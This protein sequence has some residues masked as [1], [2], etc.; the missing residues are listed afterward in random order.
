[1]EPIS[2]SK[3]IKLEASTLTSS[4]M[5]FLKAGLSCRRAEIMPDLREVLVL[6][7]L[8]VFQGHV[9]HEVWVALPSTFPGLPVAPWDVA[10][11]LL[12]TG[13]VRG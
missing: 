9:G 2:R 1:M 13:N 10:G 3:R 4:K 8:Q 5:S 6:W 11:V 7:Y 12:R